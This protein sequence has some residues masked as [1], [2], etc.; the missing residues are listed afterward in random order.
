MYSGYI[1][2]C[3]KVLNIIEKRL[4]SLVQPFISVEILPY[5]QKDIKGQVIH[6][7][8][9]PVESVDT[10]PNISSDL[11]IIQETSKQKTDKYHFACNSKVSKAIDYLNNITFSMHMLMYV[12]KTYQSY[13]MPLQ[14]KVRIS[15]LMMFNA[16]LSKQITQTVQVLNIILANTLVTLYLEIHS[17]L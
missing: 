15:L 16:L 6:F 8:S 1:P 13:L 5:G 7:P 14:E 3:L 9:V 10:V 12:I 17:N 11:V 4:I 2:Q